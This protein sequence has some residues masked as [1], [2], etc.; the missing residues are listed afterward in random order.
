MEQS[1]DT[2]LITDAFGTIQYVNPAFTLM[3]GYSREEAV[4]QNPRVLKSGNQR[5]EFYQALWNTIASGQVCT[6]RSR[7]NHY[8]IN[9]LPSQRR[10]SKMKNRI[11]APSTSSHDSKPRRYC[12]SDS[13]LMNHES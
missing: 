12:P 9:C 2:V 1:A 4:G 10:I 3:T 5:A 11:S 7:A 13:R 6:R 8:Q